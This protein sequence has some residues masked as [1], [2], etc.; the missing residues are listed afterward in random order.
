MRLKAASTN[1]QEPSSTNSTGVYSFY[2]DP[3]LHTHAVGVQV[4]APG[5]ASFSSVADCMTA[6]DADE[7]CIGFVVV[8]TANKRLVGTTCTLIKADQ[9]PDQFLQTA[10]RANPNSVAY[11]QDLPCPSGFTANESVTSCTPIQQPQQLTV[12]LRAKGRCSDAAV[13]AFKRDLA[14]YL[15]DPRKLYGVNTNSL[16]LKAHCMPVSGNTTSE[17]VRVCVSVQ[18][19]QSVF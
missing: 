1:G 6:C 14:K 16:S 8:P 13:E 17:Q 7:E 12:V 10:V 5:A 2:Q 9:R 3:G 18:R 4:P 11:P 19:E 15:S